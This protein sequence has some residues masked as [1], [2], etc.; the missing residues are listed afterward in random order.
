MDFTLLTNIN[1]KWIRNL[2]VKHRAI[3]L[4]ED[5]IG[6]NLDVLGYGNDFYI[7]HQRHDT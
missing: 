7:Q 5:N 4:P 3:K 1:A 6:E 2:N